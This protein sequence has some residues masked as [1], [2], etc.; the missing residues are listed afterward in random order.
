MTFRILTILGSP[1]DKK[2]NTRALVDDFVE[3]VS[4]AGLSVGH[5]VISIGRT[6]VQSCIGCWN[7]SG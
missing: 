1:R 4:Q 6:P 2:L 3:E 5:Q 7:C